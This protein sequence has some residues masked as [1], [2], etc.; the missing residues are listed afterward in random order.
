[1]SVHLSEVDAGYVAAG[2]SLNFYEKTEWQG[3]TYWAFSNE[4]ATD[5]AS[6]IAF[7]DPTL[8]F[9]PTGSIVQ[10]TSSPR[11]CCISMMPRPILWM[12]IMPTC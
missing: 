2:T 4:Y 5:L 3:S 11:G 12:T 8:S 1:M 6:F 10:Q 9:S 7:W